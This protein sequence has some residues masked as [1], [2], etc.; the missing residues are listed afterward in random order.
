MKFFYSAITAKVLLLVLQ[1]PSACNAQANGGFEIT[2]ED[3]Q[4]NVAI[5]PP[6]RISLFE[7]SQSLSDGGVE[8]FVKAASDLATAKMQV[9]FTNKE[10]IPYIFESVQFEA[11]EVQSLVSGRRNLRVF[12]REEAKLVVGD[13]L[14]GNE[15]HSAFKRIK[16]VMEVENEKRHLAVEY[17]TA[18]V[19]GGNF[20]F[21]LI[22]AAPSNECNRKLQKVMQSY[23]QLAQEIIS[24]NH[25]ELNPR[26]ANA[27]L[28]EVLTPAPTSTPTKGPTA[29]PTAPPSKSPTASPSKA[30][31]KKPS[32][33]PTTSPTTAFPTLSPSVTNSPTFTPP[34]SEV[35]SESP[36]KSPPG[37]NGSTKTETKTDNVLP[38]IIPL[39]SVAALVAVGAAIFVKRR[40]DQNNMKARDPDLLGRKH[41]DDSD[42]SDFDID[43]GAQV[44]EPGS[45][46]DI[47]SGG[48]SDSV[49]DSGDAFDRSIATNDTMKAGNT[50]QKW[51]KK[52]PSPAKSIGKGSYSKTPTKEPEPES[53]PFPVKL[54]QSTSSDSSTSLFDNIDDLDAASPSTTEF[55]GPPSVHSEEKKTPKKAPLAASLPGSPVAKALFGKSYEKS[56]PGSASRRLNAKLGSEQATP[57]S[58]PGRLNASPVVSVTPSKVSKEEFD[59]EWDVDLPFNWKPTSTKSAKKNSKDKK[60]SATNQSSNNDCDIEGSFPTFDIVADPPTS[61]P[62]H[63][64]SRANSSNLDTSVGTSLQSGM[65]PYQS[66]NDAHPMDWSHKGSEF[67][68]SSVGDSTLTDGDGTGNP[69]QDFQWRGRVNP[70]IVD[71]SDTLTPYST[72]SRKSSSACSSP[73]SKGSS[74]Q[75]I[76]DIVWLEKKIADVRAR[77]DRLDGDESHTTGSPPSSPMTS[78]TINRSTDSPVSTGS[79]ISANIICRDVLAPPGKLQIIIRST[80]DGPAILH[81]K[82]GSVLNGQIFAGDLIVSVNDIDTRTFDAEGVMKLMAKSSNVE[83]KITVLHAV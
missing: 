34:P 8:A 11:L 50:N 5:N 73:S 4:L 49:D 10:N 79:S 12:E 19:L 60:K 71:D 83:R 77:V 48:S 38:I 68:T 40:H 18:F 42:N 22:P 62:T 28:T 82:P 33:S 70:D 24:Q 44:I 43:N 52:S 76:N 31:S 13:N 14:V 6:I 72:A 59:Q 39:V 67:D 55:P 17:G 26:A 57:G 35:A 51:L 36:S 78:G 27:L 56:T 69:S 61:P 47:E 16:E 2:N 54:N 74:K 25:P 46:K 64:I 37:S 80:K 32:P 3:A 7:T 66:G 29:S 30:P 75:L 81:V 1:I 58:A 23:W 9:Y 45:T 41:I 21:A 53:L 15:A 63:S 65:S 20:T